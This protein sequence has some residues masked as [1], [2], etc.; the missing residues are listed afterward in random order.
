MGRMVEAVS[1]NKKALTIKSD[2]FNAHYNLGAAYFRSGMVDS[3]I[4][5]YKQAM[6]LRPDSADVHRKLAGAY[7]SKGEY[8]RALLHGKRTVELG[9]SISRQLLELIKR[10]R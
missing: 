10:Y 6:T 7:Y 8:S 4:L 5:S 9:G 2:D 1:E 3:A